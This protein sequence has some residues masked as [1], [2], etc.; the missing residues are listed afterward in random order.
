MEIYSPGDEKEMYGEKDKETEGN[1]RSI[2]TVT[3]NR[4][5]FQRLHL[6]YEEFNPF[7]VMDLTRT[8]FSDNSEL[9]FLSAT[10]N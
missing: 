9:H 3:E 5:V 4:V 2:Y 10:K 7:P 8:L 1:T 6:Q